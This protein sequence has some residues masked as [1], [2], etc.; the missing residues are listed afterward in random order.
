[1][2]YAISSMDAQVALYCQPLKLILDLPALHLQSW[3]KTG[4]KYFNQQLRAAKKQAKLNTPN[5]HTF[6]HAPAHQDNDLQQS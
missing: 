2:S 5:I 6:F 3:V 1:M 4:Y